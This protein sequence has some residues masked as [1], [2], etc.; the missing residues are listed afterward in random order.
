MESTHNKEKNVFKT[1]NNKKPSGAQY[2]KRKAEKVDNLKKNYKKLENYFTSEN[3]DCNK[4]K[5]GENAA[6]VLSDTSTSDEEDGIVSVGNVHYDEKDNENDDGQDGDV[7]DRTKETAIDYS[8]CGMWPILRNIQFVDYVIN[9]G[10]IQVNLDTYPRDNRRRHFSNAYY[11]RKLSNGEVISRRWLVYSVY[12]D[13]VFCFCCKLFDFNMN[14]KLNGNGFNKWKNLTEALKI[15]ENSKS[16]R[17]AYQLWIETEIRMKAG[18]TIDKQ[19]QKLIE[20]D[21]LRWR[22]VL[23]RL[24]NITLYLATNNMAFRGSSDKLYAVNNGKFLG[25]VQLL[26]KF[27]PIMLNHVTLAL[28]GD[29]SDHYCGKT[30]QN[31]MIDIMASKV[32][33]IIISKALKSTYYSIIADC[34][35]D[36]SHKEQLSLTMAFYLPCGSHS[37]NLVICDAAQ[38]SL[39]SINVFG[40]I[41][42]LFTLFSA[43]TSR[44]NVLLSHTTNFTLKRLCET[45]W[46]AKI[47]SLKA[48]RYQISSVHD[49]L[50]TIY[51]TETETPDIAHEAQTLAEQLKDY[52]FLVSLIAWYNVLFQINVVSKAMQAKDMDLVQCAEMLK[53]CITFLENY[54]TFGFKQATVDAK[55]LAEELN[56]DAI[57]K[58]LKRV[59]RVKRHYD[60]NAFDEPIQNPEKKLEVTFFN[61][62]LDTCLSSINERFEQLNEYVNIWSFLF[63]LD[64]LP[65]KNELLK[66][67]KQLQEKLT[68]NT[69]SEIDGALLCDELISVQFFIKDKLSNVENEINTKEMTPLFVLNLI[70]KHCLQELYSNT[71]IV[72]RILLTIP[73]TVASGER[74]FSKLKLIKTYLRN[75][76][77]Q[78][79]LNSLSMLS[80]EQDIAENLDFSSLIRDFADKKARKVRF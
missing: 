20:K 65:I 63:Y 57:F 43:S 9:I 64:N 41:Q 18:E 74:S 35:P 7:N 5:E 29:I 12:K 6:H 46:E 50:I 58:P 32:T 68:V 33:N 11:N 23:E 3:S 59:R 51:E 40:I 49:A 60:E 15:H 55:E 21:S 16:H 75:T 2:R 22:S 8:D 13:A 70:K 17:I 28:K 37:L 45:R 53:K 42:R 76:M 36:V 67:C 48:I 34:T 24:M 52:S 47:E 39:N 77:L 4:I 25:L 69:K 27:D 26:A 54:R 72:L 62:L 31:E 66:L 30:I 19:E 10:A 71:W 14:L 79:R 78:D 56:I 44:W 73:V 80:I 61:P 1:H 38:S